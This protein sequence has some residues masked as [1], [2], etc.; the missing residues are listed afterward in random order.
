MKVY[1]KH[2]LNS[3]YIP[4]PE[5]TKL[6][7]S[8]KPDEV[9]YSWEEEG[10]PFYN[11]DMEMEKARNRIGM[12]PKVIKKR[13]TASG[14]SHYCSKLT[15]PMVKEIKILL[16]L[17]CKSQKEIAQKYDIGESVI[18]NIKMGR[19]W[20]NVYFNGEDI[21]KFKERNIL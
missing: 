20:T 16:E 7:V 2:V 3:E 14:K 6:K 1:H 21:E 5:K 11:I 12:K 10:S 8:K 18:S 13:N 17:N 15:I 19:I 4:L 9:K